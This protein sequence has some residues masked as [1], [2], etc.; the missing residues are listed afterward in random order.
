M[1]EKQI[2]LG[3]QQ[4]TVELFSG[5][6]EEGDHKATKIR[7]QENLEVEFDEPVSWDDEE[8]IKEAIK[9][10]LGFKEDWP[11]TQITDGWKHTDLA[12]QGTYHFEVMMYVLEN[13]R[14]TSEDIK[15]DL[16]LN[17]STSGSIHKC[18]KRNLVKSIG[19]VGRYKVLVPTHLAYKIDWETSSDNESLDEEDELDDGSDVESNL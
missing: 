3:N 12:K 1:T 5:K 19:K 18:K 13:P 7:I 10:G 11:E 14:C 6:V 4:A 15:K 8:A 2:T 17:G 16:E 9:Q